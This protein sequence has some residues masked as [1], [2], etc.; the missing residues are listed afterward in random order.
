MTQ[1]AEVH[2]CSTSATQDPPNPAIRTKYSH[3]SIY[4][5]FEITESHIKEKSISFSCRTELLPL[6]KG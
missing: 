2:H 1:F 3:F 5:N 6:I 4:R